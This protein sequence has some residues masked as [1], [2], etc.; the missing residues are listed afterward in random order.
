MSCS[1]IGT[2]LHPWLEIWWLTYYLIYLTKSDKNSPICLLVLQTY[3]ISCDCLNLQWFSMQAGKIEV[4]CTGDL[5]TPCINTSSGMGPCSDLRGLWMSF[6]NP[7]GSGPIP[8]GER[9]SNPKVFLSGNLTLYLRDSWSWEVMYVKELDGVAFYWL[10]DVTIRLLLATPECVCLLRS[11][12]TVVVDQEI[13][14]L[15]NNY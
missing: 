7:M 5:A 11:S 6:S 10:D 8:F 14:W 3:L 1:K 2:W 13:P 12:W 9:L 15:I 4:H